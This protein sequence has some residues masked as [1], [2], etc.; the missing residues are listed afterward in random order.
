MV[1]TDGIV[2]G[3]SADCHACAYHWLSEGRLAGAVTAF[4]VNYRE[5]LWT[6]QTARACWD[7]LLPLVD[8]VV[9]SRGVSETVFGWTDDDETLAR[10]YHETFGCRWVAVT[11]REH[12]GVLRGAWNSL[13]LAD[14]T[15]YT[16]RRYAFDIVDR[17]GTGDVFFA[18]LMQGFLQGDAAFAVAF[19]NAACALAH[20]TEGD[21]AAFSAA[22]VLPLLNETFDLRVKR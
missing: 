14:G 21:V 1:H 18:G 10:R 11:T 12:E 4:D 16:G 7:M 22:D 5:H 8:V 20:T 17:Y 15:I 6:P 3:L 13:L 9:T 2:P 19:A